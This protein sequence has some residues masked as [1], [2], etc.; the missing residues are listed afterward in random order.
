MSPIFADRQR[1]RALPK[2]EIHVHLEGCFSRQQIIDLAAAAGEPLPRPADDLFSFKT[3]AEFLGFLDWSCG[4]VRIEA[5]VEAMAYAFCARL[6]E[7]GAGYADAIINPTHWPSWRH[8]LP[9]M[10]AALDRGFTAAERDGLPPVG[11]CLSLL[12]QQSA[13]E[14]IELLDMMIAHRHPRVVALSIDGNEAAAGRTG[15][16]FADTFRR[17][18]AA[19][20]H[21]TVHAG[22]SSGPDGIRDAIRLL[23]AERIDHG[24]RAAEDPALMDEIRDRGLPL[25]ITPTS[26]VRLGL[27]PS[28]AAHPIELLRQH[29][30]AVSVGTD[31]PELLET[32]LV[33]EYAH[34]VETFEWDD[35]VLRAVA[36]TSIEASFA[37]PEIKRDLVAKLA[38]W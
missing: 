23:G 33:E 28:Y 14:A 11:L 21:R 37:P 4:L 34:M 13:D 2:A 1:L 17:A 31:D 3:L 5:Q 19:G 20:F 38:V 7:N 12:R 18:A 10:I 8:R 16:R 29:G 9:A 24:V 35:D 15:P 6:A 27:Y 22:E 26:N 30:I 32:T 36:R 25:D